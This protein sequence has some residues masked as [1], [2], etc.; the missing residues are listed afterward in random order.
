MKKLFLI[1]SAAFISFSVLYAQDM[2]SA[3]ATYNEGATAL[4]EGNYQLAIEK[5]ES[6][7]SQAAVIGA[8]AED[9]AADCRKTIPALYIQVAKG[10]INDKNYD[11]ARASLETAAAKAAEFGQEEKVNEAKELTGK[12]F[13]AEGQGKLKEKDFAG[14]AAD[15]AKATE[16]DAANAQAWLL[17]GQASSRANDSATALAAFD[18]AR[19]LGLGDKVD[20]ELAK[21]YYGI[22]AAALK[23]KDFTKAYEN[24]VK[25]AAFNTPEGVKALSIAGKAAYSAKKYAEAVDCL[26]KYIA[27]NPQAK[28]MNQ[29]LYQIADSL[30]KMGKKS[31]ACG[32]FKQIPAADANFGAYAAGKVKEFGC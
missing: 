12:V 6:A 32:Y 13:L 10:M 29:T 2:E 15:F 19:E 8:D 7:L 30:E 26:T 9:L 21:Y 24:G 23:A 28:D 25:A 1:L 31:E 17:L 4:N 3:T 11:G 18:K 27:G 14:A 22:S 16:A 20:T 5:F